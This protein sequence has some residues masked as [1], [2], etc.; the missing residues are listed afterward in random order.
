[1]NASR[2]IL[3]FVNADNRGAKALRALLAKTSQVELARRTGISQSHLSRLS[4]GETKP[5][6]RDQALVLAEE[7]I[8]VDWWDEVADQP[9]NVEQCADGR[10][11]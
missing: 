9:A 4:R 1:L 2:H 6:L 10:P 11:T 5:K 3:L 8:A 7:G